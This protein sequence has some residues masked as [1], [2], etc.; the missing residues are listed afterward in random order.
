NHLAELCATATKTCLVETADEIQPSWLQGHHYVGVTG[1]AS[2]AEE[3][4]NGVLAKL[5]AMAL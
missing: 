2:T 5:E 3:T 4:I 1:G